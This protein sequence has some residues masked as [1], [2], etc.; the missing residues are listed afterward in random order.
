MRKATSQG[1]I[2][3]YTT[4]VTTHLDPYTKEG[5]ESLHTMGSKDKMCISSMVRCSQ[6]SKPWNQH[7]NGRP[8]H[9]N[10]SWSKFWLLVAAV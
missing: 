5:V 9:S 2:P 6:Q 3:I 8:N 10:N 4:V 1:V 7:S